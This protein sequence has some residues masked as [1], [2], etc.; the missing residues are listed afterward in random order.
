MRAD[1]VAAVAVD[2]VAEF[3]S[4]FQ[5]VAGA[6]AVGAAEVSEVEAEA[7]ADLVA[8][9][10]SRVVAADPHGEARGAERP[11]ACAET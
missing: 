2:A 4:S 8:V 10:V 1:V 11:T 9:A 5:W 3:P 7:S 6:V